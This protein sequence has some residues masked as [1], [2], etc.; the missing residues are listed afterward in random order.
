VLGGKY[1]EVDYG[2][3]DAL[4]A[5]AR[6]VREEKQAREDGL[7][8]M[9]EEMR[10]EREEREAARPAEEARRAEETRA[11]QAM[12]ESIRETNA[13]LKVRLE[14]NREMS[15]LDFVLANGLPMERD[16]QF[17]YHG[18]THLGWFRTQREAIDAAVRY[19]EIGVT[20]E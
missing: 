11:E 18:W 13:Y 16:G 15:R 1:K 20:E 19:P 10:Q 2:D 3:Y 4:R 8:K 12:H 6:K 14:L 7:R 17:R 5:K 9:L